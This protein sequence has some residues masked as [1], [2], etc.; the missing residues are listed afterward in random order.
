[1]V[2]WK[3]IIDVGHTAVMLP[4]AAT[5][6]AWLLAGRAW[7]MAFWWCLMFAFGLS[8][9][10]LSKMA[11]LGWDAGVPSLGFKAL[12]GHA[13]C[14][15]AVI[16]VL[17]FV[18]LQETS[19]SIRT[20]GVVVGILASLGL[21]ALLVHFAFHTSSEVVAS[22][23]LGSSISLGYMGLARTLPAPRVGG[24]MVPLALLVFAL[25]FSLKPALINHRLVNVA[26]QLSGRDRPYEW[27]NKLLCK[28][29]D[30]TR[31]KDRT[32]VRQ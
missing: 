30:P 28:S 24:W 16:P 5:I 32:R 22:F 4:V 9:V 21:G 20:A 18:L 17:L 23:V 14:A 25:A 1:M 3:L 11:F 26:L 31:G 8:L 10:A 6:A 2:F 29:P 12:S 27:S 13:F 7:K 15:T 19:I